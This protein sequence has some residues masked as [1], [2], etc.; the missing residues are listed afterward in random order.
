MLHEKTNNSHQPAP[1]RNKVNARRQ[2]HGRREQYPRMLA[3]SKSGSARK[4]PPNSLVGRRQ[5]LIDAIRGRICL[6][7]EM[8]ACSKRAVAV[9]KTA[10][11][12]SLLERRPSSRT[13]GLRSDTIRPAGARTHLKLIAARVSRWPLAAKPVGPQGS[14]QLIFLSRKLFYRNEISVLCRR[15]RPRP[16]PNVPAERNPPANLTP[17]DVSGKVIE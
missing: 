13:R 9:R 14:T 2:N 3:H 5:T 7:E 4:Y 15:L 16:P 1:G 11:R 8:P 17:P 10:R 12:Q 6:R